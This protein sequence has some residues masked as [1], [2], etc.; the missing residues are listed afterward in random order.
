[1]VSYDIK[2]S[3]SNHNQPLG[4]GTDGTVLYVLYVLCSSTGDRMHT[5]KQAFK[6]H[7]TKKLKL[8]LNIS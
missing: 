5:K 2:R 3:T 8:I 6:A 1:M 7:Q 4:D